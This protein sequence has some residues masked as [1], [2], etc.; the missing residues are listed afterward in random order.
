MSSAQAR[1]WFDYTI[2]VTPIVISVAVFWVAFNQYRLAAQKLRLD[3]YNRRFD[4][5]V[6]ALNFYQALI[7]SD[8]TD[9]CDA[10]DVKHL[11]F[12][13]AF[14][15]AQFLFRSGSGVY[16]VLDDYHKHAMRIIFRKES[17]NDKAYMSS[18]EA[19]IKGSTELQESLEII[20]NGIT[21]LEKALGPYLNFHKAR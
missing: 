16:E 10:F 4:I 6:A 15:E 19:V 5:Y 13:K 21:K 9:A 11:A 17:V 1:D 7:G 14:R 12:I 18:P 2:A 8:I 20:N 3:L